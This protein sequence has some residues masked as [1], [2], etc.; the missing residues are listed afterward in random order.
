LL[1]ILNQQNG[2]SETQWFSIK[3]QQ[4]S[5]ERGRIRVSFRKARDSCVVFSF[6]GFVMGY[7]SATIV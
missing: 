5:F 6:D 2:A 4:D 7:L 1:H 3:W